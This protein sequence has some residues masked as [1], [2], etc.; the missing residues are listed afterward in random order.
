MSNNY[1][2]IVRQNIDKLYA[3]FPKDIASAVG[4]VLNNESVEFKAFGEQCRISPDA[5]TLSGV[6]QWGVI[7]I[8]LS[9]YALNAKIM[10]CIEEPFKAFKEFPNTMPYVGAFSTHTEQIL[11]PYVE[12]IEKNLHKIPEFLNGNIYSGGDFAFVI[13]PLPKIAL[14]YIFYRAD[15]DFPAAVSC[16]YSNNASEFLPNDPLA[17][18]GE[19]SSLKIIQA[20]KTDTWKL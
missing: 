12:K 3:D 9:L 10:P 2:I 18:L 16:L 13:R 14:C 4:G 11:V 17:D 7:G 19:Y 6:E 5:I 1:A 8:I 20:V 15:E